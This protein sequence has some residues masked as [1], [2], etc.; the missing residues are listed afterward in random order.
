MLKDEVIIVGAHLD[1]V[2]SC[3]EIMPGAND[4]CSAVAVMVGA[5]GIPDPYETYHNTRDDVS[6]ITP[7]IMED[8]ARVLFMAIVDMSDEAKLEFGN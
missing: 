3:P 7:E 4:N 8:I 2:G 5:Y 6:L 1:G